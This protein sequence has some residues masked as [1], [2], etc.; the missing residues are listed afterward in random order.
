MCSLDDTL[1]CPTC[2]AKLVS[3]MH[4]MFDRI[5]YEKQSRASVM[6]VAELQE[7]VANVESHLVLLKAAQILAEAN[8]R[9]RNSNALSPKSNQE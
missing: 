4:P 3:M 2:L 9:R 7:F 5:N 1:S 8:P 6:R